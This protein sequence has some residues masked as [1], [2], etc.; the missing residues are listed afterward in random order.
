MA[1]SGYD[2]SS[3]ETKW[4]KRWE[5]A[6]LY[7][8]AVDGD[9]PKHYAL[10]MLPYTSGDLH[11]GH[12]Y[13]I[14]PSDVR[15]R[16]MRM[17]GYN[18]LFPIGFD[19]FGLPAENAAIQR[20]V[21]PFKWTMDNV[22]QMREQLKTMGTMFDWDREAIT[23]VPE[24]YYWT[25]W[26][27]LQFYKHGQAYRQKAPVDWCPSCNT[28]LAREQVQGED[29]HCERCETPVVVKELD[30]WLL[31]ITNYAE[32]LL[33]FSKIDWSDRV[34]TMQN[35]WI[36][37]SEGV[38]FEM[39]VKGQEEGFRVFTTRPDTTFGMTFAVLAPE[40]PLVARI[41][42]EDQRLEVEAYT[43]GALRR[44]EIERLSIGRAR[45]GVFTGAYAINPMNDAE[46]PIYIADYVLTTYGTGAIMAVPA[47][48]ERDF[49]FAKRYDLPIRVVIAPSDWDGNPP[50]EAYIDPGRMV[51]SGRFD[52]LSSEEGW[53]AVADDLEAR[54]IGER[55]VNYRLHDWLISRQRYWG[56]PIPIIYCSAC[57][58]VPV[59]E[60]DLP[61]L[62]PEDAAFLPTGESPLKYHEGFL[63]ATCPKC[64]G[65]AVRETDTMDTFM[66]SSWYQYRYL[67]PHYGQGPFDPKEGDYWLPVDQYTGG[68]EHATMHLLYTRFFTKAM[69]D[70]GLVDDDEPMVRLYNQGIVLGEDSEKMSKSRGN[71]INPDEWVDRYGADSVR[72]Y[73]MFFSRWDQGGPWSSSSMEG[74]PRF[75]N[76]VWSLVVGHPP[77]VEGQATEANIDALKRLMHQTVKKVSKDLEAFAFNTA[78]AALMTFTNGLGRAKATP[79]VKTEA[80]TEA[81]RTL[82]LL[83]APMTPHLAEELWERIGG[84]FSVHLQAWP[85]WDE[86]LARPA[87]IEMPVQVN[88]KVR[89]RF[90]VEIDAPQENIERLALAQENVQAHLEGKSPRKVIVVPNRL[91]NVV[92]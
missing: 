55:K 12:W 33:D 85:E 15:A 91:V 80:W 17:Q 14:A 56:C 20:G 90:E 63:H 5:E 76:R 68:I 65:D 43:A 4:R 57:G 70:M 30:Q 61:V 34:V 92:V 49:N 10:T 84:E 67:S 24:Y 23:C 73:L 47:H 27:F 19:A 53:E 50:G 28:T 21:H 59:A 9:R 69:R 32:E 66:C 42:T 16:F 6:G 11:I 75:L 89:A 72:T 38:E 60:E 46:V 8:S 29:R 64:G 51:N 35:N 88:G 39:R 45:D 83:L 2:F 77:E 71:V 78:V 86:A 31:R 40:H 25:Q 18:V 26:L 58:T 37:R 54:S 41:T 3:I 79:A 87:T 1:D 22:E 81:I 13:A 62:L 52:G 74:T 7:R 36:G 82:V 44:S 48:D